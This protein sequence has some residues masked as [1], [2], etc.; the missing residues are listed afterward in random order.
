ILI[1][2]L[3]DRINC[4]VT[5]SGGA[6]LAALLSDSSQ[7]IEVLWTSKRRQ[8]RTVGGGKNRSSTPTRFAVISL[9]GLP[10]LDPTESLNDLNVHKMANAGTK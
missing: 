10:D 7:M 3:F 5:A 8:S 4:L 2:F 9:Q 1:V 6:L